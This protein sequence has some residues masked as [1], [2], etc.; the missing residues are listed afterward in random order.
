MQAR[1]GLKPVDH[2]QPQHHPDRTDDFKIQQ[3]FETHAAELAQILH[4]RQAVH[5]CA[6]HNR[7]KHHFEQT[8]EGLSYRLHRHRPS[9]CEQSQKN[10]RDK[11]DQYLY[12]K[13]FQ[14]FH[15]GLSPPEKTSGFFVFKMKY[16][17]RRHG[18]IPLMRNRS[19]RWRR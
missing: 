6:E 13:F 2:H 4:M 15:S 3:G 11:A 8:D 14:L 10:G 1:A 7:R 19:Q 17:G 12:V 9:G 16:R 18:P 5:Q